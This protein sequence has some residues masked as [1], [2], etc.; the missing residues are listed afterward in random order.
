MEA[1]VFGFHE[2][3]SSNRLQ[4]VNIKTYLCD[5]LYHIRDY[6]QVCTLGS[7]LQRQNYVNGIESYKQVLALT[8]LINIAVNNFYRP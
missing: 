6:K 5:A 8:E 1:V 2:L 3:S 7:R 4:I